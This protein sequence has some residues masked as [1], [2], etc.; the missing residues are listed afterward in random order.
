MKCLSR[1]L[2]EELGATRENN[3]QNRQNPPSGEGF[4]GFVGFAGAWR[5]SELRAYVATLAGYGVRLSRQAGKLRIQSR[6]P[7]A[8]H[9]IADLEAIAEDLAPVQE[10]GPS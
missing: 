10:G 1:C 2:S 7:L 8:G 6:A 5:E 4:V 9:E 3:R